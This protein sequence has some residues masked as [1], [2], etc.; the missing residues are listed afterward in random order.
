MRPSSDSEPRVRLRPRVIVA[1]WAA[2]ALIAGARHD[3]STTAFGQQ[4][5]LWYG[6]AMQLPI[7]SFWAALTPLIFWLARR[8]PIRRARWVRP[9]AIHIAISLAIVWCL[10]ILYAAYLQYMGSIPKPPMQV[11]PVLRE[12]EKLFVYFVLEDIMLYW[13]VLAVAHALDAGARARARELRGS[14]LEVQLAQ[15]ELQALKM[16]IHPHFLF[17]ALHTISAL[18]RTGRS[19]LAVRVIGRLGDLLRRM[20]D[21]ASAQVVPLREELEFARNYLEV[22]QARFPDRLSVTWA[23][24]DDALS[25]PVPHLVLQP[26]LE[27][28]IHHGIAASTSAQ[29]IIVEARIAKEGLHLTVRDDGPGL[30]SGEGEEGSRGVGLANIRSRL[31]RLY[32]QR[33]GL[34]V[35]G[36]GD[37]GVA[38]H[39]F[40]PLGEAGA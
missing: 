13:V 38:A 40:V 16:Q 26:L 32:G 25:A 23:V 19:A 24:A 22:E 20:V 34:E 17:N 11:L 1:V 33:A 21:G 36:T 14:Q 37:R 6:F 10:Y 29:R 8:F 30:G 31:A 35:T 3:L 2:Y 4:I 28:A 39:V 7:A 5:P 15:A 9:L 18:V 27:N 12:A